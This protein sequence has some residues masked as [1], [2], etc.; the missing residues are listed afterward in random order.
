MTME[1]IQD[2]I[3]HLAMKYPNEPFDEPEEGGRSWSLAPTGDPYIKI[4]IQGKSEKEVVKGALNAIGF[5]SIGKPKGCTLYWRVK[6]ELENRGK[7]K[8]VVYMRCVLSDKPRLDTKDT[9]DDGIALS[10][11]NHPVGPKVG[12]GHRIRKSSLETVEVEIQNLD[13]FGRKLFGGKLTVKSFRNAKD[14]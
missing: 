4:L 12:R 14:D 9:A 5:H 6:P 3:E 11:I 8:Y 10:C 1:T 13:E 2:L 7:S